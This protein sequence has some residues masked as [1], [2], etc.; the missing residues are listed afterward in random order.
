MSRDDE[1]LESQARRAQEA[2]P[3]G[4]EEP[5]GPWNERLRRQYRE[6]TSPV[7]VGAGQLRTWLE[8]LPE[9]VQLAALAL[10][11]AGAALVPFMLSATLG[12]L[13][14]YWMDIVIK[15]GIAAL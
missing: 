2:T 4:I 11:I 8:G 5:G 10:L 15:I 12:N 14:N 1:E 7:R 6:L 3:G 13:Y 9:P